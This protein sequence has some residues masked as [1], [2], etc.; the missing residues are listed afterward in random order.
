MPRYYF[1]LYNDAEVLDDEGI[2]HPDLAAARQE[3]IRGARALIAEHVVGG[4][5]VTLS[6]RIEIADESRLVRA[7]IFFREVITVI[8]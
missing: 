7:T 4:R 5:P 2:E 6:H 1:N 8:D 3:A